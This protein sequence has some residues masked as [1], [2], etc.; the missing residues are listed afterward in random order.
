MS[1]CP[2]I[3]C[4][5]CRLSG[6]MASS[7][8][9]KNT[10]ERRAF[11]ATANTVNRPNIPKRLRSEEHEA[12]LWRKQ[13]G[14]WTEP[15][16]PCTRRQARERFDRGADASRNEQLPI[17]PTNQPIQVPPGAPW[18]TWVGWLV[19]MIGSCSFLLVSRHLSNP[20]LA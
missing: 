7:C 14:S 16:A 6:H 8:P 3:L 11:P 10:S 9:K 1:S 5:S 20:S 13:E 12:Q 19:R 17:I 15:P 2:D 4:F 18:V